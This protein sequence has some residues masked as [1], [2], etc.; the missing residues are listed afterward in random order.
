[1]QAVDDVDFGERLAGALPQ[2]VPRLLERHR[3]RAGVAGPQPRER[4]EQAARDADVGR[5][6]ADVEVVVGRARRAASRAR[7][8]RAS[9]ARACRDTRTAAR[10]RRTTG[11][12]RRPASR[13][14]RP[15]L[16]SPTLCSTTLDYRLQPRTS[17]LVYSPLFDAA[18][19][20]HAKWVRSPRGA[21]T[22]SGERPP[23]EPLSRPNAAAR[24]SRRRSGKAEGRDDPRARIPGRPGPYLTQPMRRESTPQ[25][26]PQ[27]C[28]PSSAC[29]P[30]PFVLAAGPAPDA[31]SSS[32]HPDARCRARS[33]RSSPRTDRRPRRRS[34]RCRRHRS[35]SPI[36]PDVVPRRRPSL[37]GFQTAS[38]TVP[39][40]ASP[41]RL[42]LAVAPVSEAI[43]VSATRTEAPA[44]QVAA[45]VTVFD[46]A[47]IE[48]K[49][50]PLLADLLRDA[51][52]TTDR[53]HRRPRH[54]DVALRP[55]RREQLHESPA[56]RHSAERARRRVQPEQRDDGEPRSR[57]VRARRQFRALRIRR[58]D[59]RHPAVH[60]PAGRRR[61]RRRRC[62]SK[63]DRSRRRAAPAG[64]GREGGRVRLLG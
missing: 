5:F 19:G 49:Q 47:E 27:C 8:W 41:M 12:R 14:Y 34:D 21:A 31:V 50:Q 20:G 33:C 45:S 54:G 63:A 48:R 40:T 32:I 1:M 9:R 26:G 39:D 35:A 11:A 23:Q 6:E 13:R 55:R 46:G 15:A 42:T 52:G 22:V 2:L 3:V 30:F 59:R 53:A 18:P 10:R 16:R 37:A 44:G 56:R 64:V 62:A 36:A 57:R 7:G 28:C 17:D 25:G 60:A 61:S 43:V 4:A 38:A 51:P 58:D 24:V 29:S